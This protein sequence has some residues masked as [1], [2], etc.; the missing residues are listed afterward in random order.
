MKR[1]PDVDC[2]LGDWQCSELYV[3]I[4]ST[5]GKTPQYKQNQMKDLAE[6]I[7]NNWE[8]KFK[9][10]LEAHVYQASNN[11]YLE[12]S[13]ASSFSRFLINQAWL[14]SLLT[15]NA[16]SSTSQF[17]YKGSELFNP[18]SRKIRMLLHT[19]APYLNADL[20]CPDFLA[21]LKVRNDV[22]KPELLKYL[23]EWSQMSLLNDM[24][25][26]T[27]IDHMC[28]VY[29]E[30]IECN[31]SDIV[32]W[33]TDECVPLIFV[34]RKHE[35]NDTSKDVAGQFLSIHD[36]CW[37]DPTAV[38]YSKQ[39]ANWTL[40][41]NLPKILSL[42][43]KDPNML[44]VFSK[45]N[46]C[47]APLIK[48]YIALLKYVSSLSVNP[49]QQHISDFA[50]IALHL[51]R[52][53]EP[54]QLSTA[55]LYNN[56]K[57]VKTFP[58]HHRVWITLK[59]CLLENDSSKLSNAFSLLEE[60]HFLE[61]PAKIDQKTKV[62]QDAMHIAA[63]KELFLNFCQ[64]P[65]LSSK[66]RTL[67]D[68]GGNIEP[69]EDL[70]ARISLWIPVTQKFLA[71]NCK[72]QYRC[73][74][75]DNIDE[76][77]LRLLVLSAQELKCFHYIEHNGK[78]LQCPL[79]ALETCVLNIDVS[80]IHTIYVSEK[81][82]EKPPVFLL[83]PFMQLFMGGTND[84]Q[85]EEL[86]REFMQALLSEIPSDQDEV[87]ELSKQFQLLELNETEK[88]WRVPSKILP[89]IAEEN[90]SEEEFMDACDDLSNDKESKP[91]TS[92]P[93]RSVSVQQ[94]SSDKQQD[95]LSTTLAY[96]GGAAKMDVISEEDVIKMRKSEPHMTE[97]SQTQFSQKHRPSENVRGPI[98]N[99]VQQQQTSTSESI[100][101]GNYGAQ[102][103]YI[104]CCCAHAGGGYEHIAC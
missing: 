102:F 14:P 11:S 28:E 9:Q 44:N 81:K 1:L 6:V 82:K 58:S 66:V 24:W 46:I 77:L 69:L 73:L 34:P 31:D 12:I 78:R 84:P 23:T 30:L 5:A 59:D 25:F 76:I 43:Y 29:K 65:K 100:N 2:I 54:L 97:Q 90:S 103:T 92:W 10:K 93:P 42:H 47:S 21:F 40:P 3:I 87:E 7:D 101:K 57:D 17:L 32:K 22:T 37:Q 55:Y 72:S 26:Y 18:H 19:H 48:T 56:L 16:D 68:P 60:V 96:R 8:R 80:G 88:K 20:H 67:T 33:F 41:S 85:E 49:E 39:R 27:S 62:N 15:K 4:Q 36:V 63:D 94:S 51:T 74:L 98:R 95:K 86:F 45:V 99:L 91:F 75:Q 38:L 79:P 71:K 83:N 89:Q 61:W 13:V 70:K 64:I 104:G 53:I 52:E 50:S 35:Q